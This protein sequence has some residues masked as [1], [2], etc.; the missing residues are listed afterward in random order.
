MKRSLIWLST[1]WCLSASMAG[2]D[3]HFAFVYVANENS[4]TVTVIDRQ[5]NSVRATIGVGTSPGGVAVTPD[6]KEAWV[7]AIGEVDVID[8][9]TNDVAVTFPLN[10]T[11]R[12][13]PNSLVFSPDGLRAYIVNDFVG[14]IGN[15]TVSVIDRTNHAIVDTIKV[16]VDPFSIAITP[17]GKRLYVTDSIAGTVSVID[18]TTR[19]VVG[20]TPSLGTVLGLAA[21]P[22]GKHVYVTYTGPDEVVV[23]DT[24]TDSIGA[25]VPIPFN[26]SVQSVPGD[27]AITPN[28]RFAYVTDGASSRVTVIDTES[29]RVVMSIPIPLG[30]PSAATTAYGV[31]IDPQGRNA[32]VTNYATGNVVVIDIHDNTVVDTIAVGSGSSPSGIAVRPLP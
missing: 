28:G 5:T 20:T 17:N 2:A 1:V 15:G 6:G 32:Y 10:N 29:N 12:P 14:P 21:G 7:V 8:T 24:A 22:D 23:I 18:T 27:V 26:N 9:A 3:Q 31:A 16:G 25:N 4:N 30:E 13:Y 19:R 11:I